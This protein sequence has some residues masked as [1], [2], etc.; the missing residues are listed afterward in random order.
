[1]DL[2]YWEP[3]R[4]AIA[5]QYRFVACDLRYHG[6]A[7]WPDAGQHFSTTT[8]SAD[9][10]A[11][12]RR[13]NAG[14]VHLVGLSSGGRLVTHGGVESTRPCTSLTVLEPPIDE[15]WPT[16]QRFNRCAMSG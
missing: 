1:M 14:P 13:L 16:C 10:A 4:H 15:R 5:L 6:P 3:Q 12:I 7:A 2:R 11:F 9:L 8:H